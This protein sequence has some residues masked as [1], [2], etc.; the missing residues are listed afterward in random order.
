[1]QAVQALRASAQATINDPTSTEADV[2]AAKGYLGKTD[3]IANPQID[4]L[5]ASQTTAPSVV[6]RS[7]VQGMAHAVNNP[8]SLAARAGFAGVGTVFSG[9]TMNP[10]T[11]ATSVDALG[12]GLRGMGVAVPGMGMV[13]QL[14]G[15]MGVTAPISGANAFSSAPSSAPPAGSPGA[16]AGSPNGDTDDERGF[17]ANL[18]RAQP[19]NAVAR[20]AEAMGPEIFAAGGP[21]EG[22]STLLPEYRLPFSAP[23]S[24]DEW[25]SDQPSATKGFKA[26]VQLGRA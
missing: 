9:A 2:A 5:Q 17:D 4:P 10:A 25:S 13:G 20:L 14:A 26:V 16:V 23:G 6:G 18:P 8:E 24:T 11:G 22:F 15:K 1:M 7:Q 3:H 12:T 19:T 21:E